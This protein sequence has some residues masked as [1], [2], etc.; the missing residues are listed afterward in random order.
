VH[1]G[2]DYLL[3]SPLDLLHALR[4]LTPTETCANAPASW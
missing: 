4:E 2:A 3:D 1:W